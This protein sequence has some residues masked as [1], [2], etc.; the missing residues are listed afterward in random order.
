MVLCLNASHFLLFFK[1]EFLVR[2]ARI[3]KAMSFELLQ[4]LNFELLTE[5]QTKN[6][7]L[8]SQTLRKNAPQPLKGVK[9][10]SGTI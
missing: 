4:T 9:S 8:I 5:L 1:H 6:F 3:L 2:I 10:K 7:K